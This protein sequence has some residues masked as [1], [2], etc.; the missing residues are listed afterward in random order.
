MVA[1]ISAQYGST[2]NPQLCAVPVSQP[3]HRFNGSRYTVMFWTQSV[4][5]Q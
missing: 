1:D 3:S 2:V 4:S 5:C